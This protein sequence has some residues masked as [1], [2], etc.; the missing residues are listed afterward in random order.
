MKIEEFGDVWDA[1]EDTPEEAENMRLRAELMRSIDG[2]IKKQSL[3]QV[4]A[5][6]RFGVTQ[7]RISDLVRGKISLFSLDALIAMA[8]KGGMSVHIDIRDAA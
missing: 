8:V 7:P 2:V 1:I 6:K 3:T 5:A 4:E